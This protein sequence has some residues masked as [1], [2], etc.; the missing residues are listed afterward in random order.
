M[1]KEA[2]VAALIDGKLQL[3]VMKHEPQNVVAALSHATK[4]EAYEQSLSA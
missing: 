4:L 3:A 2:F 1:A